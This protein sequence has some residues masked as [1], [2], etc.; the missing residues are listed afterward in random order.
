MRTIHGKKGSK[1]NEEFPLSFAVPGE[2][3]KSITIEKSFDLFHID[4]F[5]LNRMVKQYGSSILKGVTGTANILSGNFDLTTARI[6]YFKDFFPSSIARRSY[7]YLQSLAKL[8]LSS[9]YFTSRENVH[10]YLLIQTIYGAGRLVYLGNTYEIQPGDVFLIDCRK[11]HDYRSVSTTGWEY[12]MAHFDGAAMPDFYSQILSG[13]SIKL[14]LNKDSLFNEL[15]K[16]LFSINHF[17]GSDCEFLSHCVLTEL[18]T[19]ILKVTPLSMNEL[20]ERIK[21]MYE[22]ISAHCIEKL[23]LDVISREVAMSKYHMSREFKRWTGKSIFNFISEAR[24]NTA[25]RLL[26]Y[27]NLPISA[28][29]ESVG[30]EDQSNFCR[31][32]RRFEGLTPAAYRKQW[33]GV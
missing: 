19:E 28:I 17:N 27:T 8:N 26:R 20:P 9:H 29:T 10:S 6:D 30:F 32:F 13:G 4:R 25:K 23:S 12:R 21:N 31:L 14:Q 15:F 11:P 22:W 1:E 33:N 3:T 18:I 16:K 7:L 24:I 2:I 5:E